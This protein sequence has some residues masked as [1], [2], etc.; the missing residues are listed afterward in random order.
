MSIALGNSALTACGAGDANADG[1][2]TIDE[3]LAAVNVALSGCSGSV[4]TLAAH[5][6][7]GSG[8]QTVAPAP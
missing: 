3:I 5:R 2:I 7:G 6:R 1:E 4:E 8:L